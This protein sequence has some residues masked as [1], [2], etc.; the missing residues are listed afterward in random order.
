MN[1]HRIGYDNLW[2]DRSVIPVLTPLFTSYSRGALL[3]LMYGTL[4]M[5][6]QHRVTASQRSGMPRRVPVRP[7]FL[8][9]FQRQL[10]KTR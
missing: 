8:V 6:T 7:L 10:K 9:A 1:E 2:A 4:R 5:R 3:S